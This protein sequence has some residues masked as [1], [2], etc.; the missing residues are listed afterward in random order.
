M[1]FKSSNPFLILQFIDL[2]WNVCLVYW[3]SGS[4]YKSTPFPYHFP[5]HFLSLHHGRSY[6]TTG[7]S[8][9]FF[10]R[11]V[12]AIWLLQISKRIFVSHITAAIT[13]IRSLSPRTLPLQ[14]WKH[15]LI[16]ARV[17]AIDTLALPLTVEEV[18]FVALSYPMARSRT[19][20]GHLVTF[21][22]LVRLTLLP[23]N[24]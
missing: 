12:R 16:F 14:R 6:R 8:P 21:H 1:F 23:E 17:T 19:R 9:T 18:A 11:P 10:I 24:Q 20:L 13:L 2:T 7:M 22:A 4:E 15:A 3:L 5:H